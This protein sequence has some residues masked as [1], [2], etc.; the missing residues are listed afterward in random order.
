MTSLD[1]GSI[2]RE[3]NVKNLLIYHTED[4]GPDRRERMTQEAGS[5]FSGNIFVPEDMETVEL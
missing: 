3:M 4:Y 5:V 2:A 1:V